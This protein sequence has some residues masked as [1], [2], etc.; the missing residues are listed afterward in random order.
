MDDPRVQQLRSALMNIGAVAVSNTEAG[1]ILAAIDAVSPS[2]EYE[3]VGWA[4]PNVKDRHVYSV[5]VPATVPVFVRVPTTREPLTNEGEARMAAAL[6]PFGWTCGPDF[7]K[8]YYSDAWVFNLANAVV[9]L[10]LAISD[11]AQ[12]EGNA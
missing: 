2:P 8:R 1:D 11:T 3:Q 4:D 6:K 7:W 10:S 9:A 5:P 12:E